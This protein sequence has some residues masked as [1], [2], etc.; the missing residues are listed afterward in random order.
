[1][2]ADVAMPGELGQHRFGNRPDAE[3][4]RGAVGN[5]PG[6]Q[7]SD[8]L[9]G[10]PDL[11]GR[12]LE[13]LA[14]GFD[15][16]MRCQRRGQFRAVGPRRVRIDLSNDDAGLNGGLSRDVVGQ[17]KAV[18]PAIL[19]RRKLEECDVGPRLAS[20]EGPAQPS[21]GRRDHAEPACSG[22]R[23][24]SAE[25][26]VCGEAD[27]SGVIG[28]KGVG[29]LRAQKN[30]ERRQLILLL[31]QAL[32]QGPRLAGS[33]AE[34]DAVSRANNAREIEFVYGR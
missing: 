33:L 34:D 11:S 17:G 9:L 24:G 4:Q 22:E 27:S 10:W 21:V 7:P 12:Q 18:A 6:H 31:D 28:M 3:L 20:G 19:S 26:A 25:S 13:R 29:E 8:R 15:E 14:P 1:M 5:E 32:G 16:E 30:F 2:N 23:C